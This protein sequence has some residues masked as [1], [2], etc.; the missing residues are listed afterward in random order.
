M[1]I[2]LNYF[3]CILIVVVLVNCK[4][5][6]KDSDTSSAADNSIAE[7]ISIDMF[8]QIK[9]GSQKAEDGMDGKE[10]FTDTVTITDGCW[11]I[12][13]Y[14]AD[15]VAPYDTIFPLDLILDFG[16][17]GCQGQ[18]GKIRKGKI[19]VHSTGRYLLEG[20][21]ITAESKESDNPYQVS[22]DGTN[23]YKVVGTHIITNIGRTPADGD[24]C[25]TWTIQAD[26]TITKP[27]GG[28]I[29][30]HCSRE[31]EWIEGE[32]TLLNWL[33]DGF[34]HRG[35]ANGTSAGGK[36][37]TITTTQD[38]Y[39]TRDCKW[40]RSGILVINIEGLSTRTVDFGDGTCDNQA[41]V[42]I[43]GTIYNITLN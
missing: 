23:F 3:I 32:A 36:N 8:G 35:D 25:L 20:T 6:P 9:T 11:T 39:T 16:T 28:Q 43:D 30:W 5:D 27:D 17:A 14:P 13:A 19:F 18:D 31:R 21:V 34:Y 33:D 42:T 26:K 24:T 22:A 2:K 15:N 1:K 7:N 10:V 38:L 12:T 29:I 37:F 40:I 4:K 41:T